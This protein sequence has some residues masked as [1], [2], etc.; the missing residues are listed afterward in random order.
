MHI[1]FAKMCE[2]FVCSHLRF[3]CANTPSTSFFVGLYVSFLQ[4]RLVFNLCETHKLDS[5]FIIILC[6]LVPIIQTLY[7][8]VFLSIICSDSVCV[9]L[10]IAFVYCDIAERVSY[11]QVVKYLLKAAKKPKMKL[12]AKIV[13]G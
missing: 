7:Y 4:C 12:L 10:I 8:V 9:F 1:H 13:N 5:I 6:C 11:S 3:A 2:K